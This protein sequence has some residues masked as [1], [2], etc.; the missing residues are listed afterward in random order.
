[1]LTLTF[2]EPGPGPVL[3]RGP[4]EEIRADAVLMRSAPS[5]EVIAR[6]ENHCW[7]VGAQKFFRVDCEHPVR[8][9]FEGADGERSEEFG[10]F[11]HFSS[12]DG[13]AYADGEICGHIDV[14]A[15]LWYCHRDERYWKEIVV[16]P[17]G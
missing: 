15:C 13:V 8:V 17:A 14:D 1:M 16:V 9:H 10:P 11:F 7:R 6:H 5:G 4:F 12:A 3:H 2:A